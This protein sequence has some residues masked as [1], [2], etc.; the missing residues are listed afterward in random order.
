MCEHDGRD[1]TT[2]LLE[3]THGR[4]IRRL[5]LVAVV[6]VNL[7]IV[8]VLYF[9]GGPTAHNN[10]L[11]AIGR[12]RAQLRS[13]C[14]SDH[15]IDRRPSST[16]RSRHGQLTTWHPVDRV[17]AVIAGAADPTVRLLLG[18]CAW[19]T[20]SSGRDPNLRPRPPCSP[21]CA[22]RFLS[23]VRGPPSPSGRPPTVYEGGTPFT[24]FST[25]PIGWA[26]VPIS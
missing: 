20:S 22:P 1:A 13:R 24:S 2:D 14:R 8:E 11:T 23:F 5:V 12:S 16:A 3:R 19:T 10:P 26:F 7:V 4:P 18:Y 17:H 9:T 25:P 6:L 15:V 21:G